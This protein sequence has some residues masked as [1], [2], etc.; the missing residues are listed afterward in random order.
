MVKRKKDK[1]L[2]ELALIMNTHPG[3]KNAEASLR[4]EAQFADDETDDQVSS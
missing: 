2:V 1:A 3:I 4:F